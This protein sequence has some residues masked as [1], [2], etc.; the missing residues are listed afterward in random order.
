[1]LRRLH[2]INELEQENA[3][4]TGLIRDSTYTPCVAEYGEVVEERML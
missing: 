3:L 4:K 1:M 2:P